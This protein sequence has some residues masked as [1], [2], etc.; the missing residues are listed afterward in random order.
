MLGQQES[1]NKIAPHGNGS[2]SLQA[3]H[4]FVFTIA[5]S[6]EQQVLGDVGGIPLSGCFVTWYSSV[7]VHIRFG[8]TGQVGSATTSDILLPANTYVDWRHREFEEAYF[9]VIGAAAG[10]TLRHWRS[11]T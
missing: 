5:A 4:A 6:S 3:A 11:Q 10:G 1:I 8:R 9:S 7:D 2:G